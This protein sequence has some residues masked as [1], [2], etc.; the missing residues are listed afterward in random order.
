M[1]PEDSDIFDNAKKAFKFM[2]ESLNEIEIKNKLA[3]GFESKEKGKLLTLA[4]FKEMIDFDQK[5]NALQVS[6]NNPIE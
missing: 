3:I 2:P 4:A 6:K 5:L 1:V